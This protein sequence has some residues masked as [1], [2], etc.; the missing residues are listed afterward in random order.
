MPF[1]QKFIRAA[2]QGNVDEM[3]WCLSNGTTLFTRDHEGNTALL[4]AAK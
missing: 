1:D 4:I 3:K 2:L